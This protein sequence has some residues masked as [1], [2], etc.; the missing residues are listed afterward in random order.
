KKWS[1]TISPSFWYM[2]LKGTIYMPPNPSQLPEIEPTYDIDI[3]FLDMAKSI[4]FAMMLFGDVQFDR[5]SLRYNLT[6]LILEGEGITP[7]DILVKDLEIRLVYFAG[8]ASIGYSVFKR[9]KIAVD[10]TVGVKWVYSSI[11]LQS[12]VLGFYPVDGYRSFK[13]V[14][15]LMGYNVRYQP[16][17]KVKFR[18]YG[19]VG[20]LVGNEVTYQLLA[21]GSY[22]FAKWFSTSLGYRYWSAELE[23]E[24][25]AYSGNVRGW[26]MRIDFRI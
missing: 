20:F 7:L 21:E 11:A 17:H 23:N 15:P 1:L 22:Y 25:A 3:K 19:D 24:K 5:F 8:D 10:V 2:G 12:S 14:D 18:S 26:F 4:K 13:W 6:N 9:A 16:H